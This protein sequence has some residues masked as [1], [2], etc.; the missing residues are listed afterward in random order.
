MDYKP[1]HRDIYDR[2]RGEVRH[3]GHGP[4][5]SVPKPR[6]GHASSGLPNLIVENIPDKNCNEES[7]RD[8]F[9]RF[10]TIVN[11]STEPESHLA[12]LEYS[13]HEEAKACHE[14]PEPIFGNRFVK[15]YWKRVDPKVVTQEQRMAN[16]VKLEE[17]NLERDAIQMEKQKKLLEIQKKT[18]MMVK[19]R[20]D[21]QE[22]VLSKLRDDSI[23]IQ[24]RTVLMKGLSTLQESIKSLMSGITSSTNELVASTSTTV[25]I[26]PFARR[27]DSRPKTFKISNLSAEQSS[28]LHEHYSKMMGFE[29]ISVQEDHSLICFAS[30]R[31]AEFVMIFH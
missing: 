5:G 9:G 10:G 1:R 7:I 17:K 18:R 12:H 3:A 2:S 27:S 6:Y 21:E 15:V 8:F 19:E 4:R 16:L 30:R 22:K 20:M 28:R 31:E 25:P 14:S 29:S 23:S 13:T 26:N 24:E 11:V